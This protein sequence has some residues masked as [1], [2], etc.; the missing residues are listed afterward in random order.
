MG[1]VC[2]YGKNLYVIS[3]HNPDEAQITDVAFV[4]IKEEEVHFVKPFV[5]PQPANPFQGIFIEIPLLMY[6][7]VEA[8]NIISGGTPIFPSFID[9]LPFM[10]H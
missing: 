10:Y 2:R 9:T 3:D 7:F 8:H 5:V 4:C 6:P 1:C